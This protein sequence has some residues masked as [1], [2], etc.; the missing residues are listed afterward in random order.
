MG[1]AQE[2]FGRKAKSAISETTPADL[3]CLNSVRYISLRPFKK[4]LGMVQL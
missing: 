4:R 1:K 3:F 2:C